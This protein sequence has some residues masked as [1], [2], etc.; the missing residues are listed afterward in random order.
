VCRTVV[1]FRE[2]ERTGVR[3]VLLSWGDG[4]EGFAFRIQLGRRYRILRLFVVDGEWDGLSLERL[5]T[6]NGIII[7]IRGVRLE[8][9]L[10]LV[11]GI[12]V[13]WWWSIEER[14]WW[15]FLVPIGAVWFM[16]GDL[17]GGP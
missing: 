9:L 12:R 16:R 8:T 6:Q 15:T 14:L 10:S 3:G 11:L 5:G 2:E 1:L 17:V 7:M 4:E 13:R